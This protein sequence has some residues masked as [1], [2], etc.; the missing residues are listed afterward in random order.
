MKNFC[1]IS[2]LLITCIS[3]SYAGLPD[4]KGFYP[5][6][7]SV[8]TPFTSSS[9]PIVIIDLNEKMA[10]KDEDRRVSATMK[11]I[12]NQAGGENQ[13]TDAANNYKGFIE[14]KYR[15]NTSYSLSEKKPF[16]IRLR[17]LSGNKYSMSIMG[18]GSD[19][20]WALLAPYNDKSMIRDMLTYVLMQGTLDYV[21]TGRYCELILDG[22]YQGVYIMAAR[23][24]H[25]DNRINVKKPTDATVSGMRGYLLE[26][27]R[28]EDPCIQSSVPLKDLYDK[29]ISGRTVYYML[30][31]PD[32]EDLSTVLGR[33]IDSPMGSDK[34][35][36]MGYGKSNCR[37]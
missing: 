29:N 3:R 28:R 33:F 25:G 35:R 8:N 6:H 27:D 32:L 17:D 22:I 12:W 9:L 21:P 37:R 18:M 5:Y 26:I 10:N 19:D 31:H 36:S 7:P 23:A 16:A 24:R 4:P 34:K 13:V 30:K 14:I 20:D 1:I 15:G 11:V 2:L